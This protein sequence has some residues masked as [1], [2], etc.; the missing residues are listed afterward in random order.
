V[1]IPWGGMSCQAAF[2]ILDGG[3]AAGS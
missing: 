1:W 2:S 3:K